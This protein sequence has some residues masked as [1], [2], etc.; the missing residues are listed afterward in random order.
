[1]KKNLRPKRTGSVESV[2]RNNGSPTERKPSGSR[3]FCPVIL[4]YGLLFLAVLLLLVIS[5]SASAEIPKERL[6]SNMLS[7]AEYLCENPVFFPVREGRDSSKIDRYADSILLSI[8]YQ[9]H[10]LKS[11]MSASY[12]YTPYQN[13][14][15]NLL[16]SIE[17]DLPANTQY[18]RYWHGS[19]LFVRILH[20]FWN[21]RGI[22]RFHGFLMITLFLLLEAMLFKRRFKAGAFGLAVSFTAVSIWYVPLSLEYTWT[23][24]ITL[25]MSILAVRLAGPGGGSRRITPS[26]TGKHFSSPEGKIKDPAFRLGALFLTGGMVTSYLDFLTTETLTFLLPMMLYLSICFKEQET[27]VPERAAGRDRRHPS[28][29]SRLHQ[30]QQVVS[31]PC[32]AGP[33]P[34]WRIVLENGILWTVG[35]VGMWGMKWLLASIILQENVTPYIRDHIKERISGG[36]DLSLPRYLLEALTRN[37]R[38]LL[39]FEYGR[40]GYILSGV[41]AAGIILV[42]CLCHKNNINKKKLLVYALL[43][44]IPCLRFLVLRNHSYIHYFFTFRAL[45]ASILALCLMIH[46][47]I[48]LPTAFPVPGKRPKQLT[49]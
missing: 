30:E 7:S 25:A 44:I 28:C 39:P 37:L 17:A 12:Y 48:S 42:I 49:C 43:G 29:S 26:R 40:V 9:M 15:R 21:I 34:I 20:L 46:E 2:L 14:N 47:S 11:V 4:R 13:E 33:L 16:D 32:K 6:R 5:L 35:Y 19:A 38:C 1:M 24:L 22:Y 3:K 45:A 27:A 18:L 8:A 31:S 23:V 10:D 36:V 41:F